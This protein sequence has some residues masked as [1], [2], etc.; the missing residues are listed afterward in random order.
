[1]LPAAVV[2]GIAA[3][4]LSAES[5]LDKIAKHN[6][7]WRRRVGNS[8]HG[9]IMDKDIDTSIFGYGMTRAPYSFR[10][11]LVV[12]E[13]SDPIAHDLIS[14]LGLQT[15]ATAPIQYLEIGV[16]VLKCISTQVHAWRGATITAFDVEDPNPTQAKRWGEPNELK[17]WTLSGLRAAESYKR[18]DGKTVH[19]STFLEH[20]KILNWPSSADTHENDIYYVASDATNATGWH[21]LALA[22]KAKGKPPFNLVLSDGLHTAGALAFELR[23]MQKQG[24][25]AHSAE[26]PVSVIWDDCDHAL[27]RTVSSGV[28]SVAAAL[29]RKD[30]CF[31]RFNILGWAGVNEKPHPTCLLTS[32]KPSRLEKV[33]PKNATCVPVE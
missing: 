7:V 23:H 8:A 12:D 27:Q 6:A 21:E 15:Q 4:Q 11:K 29:G 3:V 28:A 2:F 1:M 20:D 13:G 26:G 33:L 22:H 31:V 24:F 18:P 17:S 9:W 14:W 19:P 30:L 5:P 32:I 10:S 16:S 25:L